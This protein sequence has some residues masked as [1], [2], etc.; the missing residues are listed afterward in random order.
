MK[1]Y[2]YYMSLALDLA[3]KGQYEVKS[4]PMV[5]CVIVKNNEIIAKGF[6]QKFGENHAEINALEKINFDA[7]NCDIYITLEPCSHFGKTP[8]CVDSV[9][10]S[11]PKKVII[12]SLDPNPKVVSIKKME[13][14][15]IEVIVG[16]MSYEANY[17]NRGFFHRMQTGLPFLTCKIASSLDGKT[18]MS[19]GE[20]KWI[21]GSCVKNDVF[22]LRAKNGAI[23]TGS[24]TVLADN[25]ML[26]CRIE[27]LPSPIKIVM[28]RSAKITD[29]KLNIF[30]GEK[31]IITDKKPLEILKL[32]G[33]ENINNCLLEAGSTLNN[34][35]L[36]HINEL[37][38]YTAPIIMGKNAKP[39]FATELN[40]MN[41]KIN[42][43]IIS[44]EL[45]GDDIKTIYSKL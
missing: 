1:D 3:K 11:N 7:K 33:K 37:I 19:S 39:M 2:K 41:E 29:K 23:I 36:L 22:K 21:T 10:K 40:N 31:T 4:N 16:I 42:F 17:L 38:V 20:S 5:G 18:A 8:P 30:S 27:N 32:L 12:A 13:N 6:H 34:S 25:P 26:N 24:G 35:F 9:I 15:G 28:D 14:A 45:V 44:I 43:K